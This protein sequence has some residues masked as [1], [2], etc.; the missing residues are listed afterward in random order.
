MID[1]DGTLRIWGTLLVL[2]LMFCVLS[3]GNIEWEINVFQIRQ[4]PKRELTSFQISEDHVRW[5]EFQP[6]GYS[7]SFSVPQGKTW[8][9]DNFR[10]AAHQP[11]SRRYRNTF[12]E[13]K[14]WPS[15]V[16]I[17][18]DRS[19]PRNFCFGNTLPEYQPRFILFQLFV[20][21]TSIPLVLYVVF[22]QIPG[23]AEWLSFVFPASQG[24]TRAFRFGRYKSSLCPELYCLV[25]KMMTAE[26][27][28]S[29]NDQEGLN[30]LVRLFV[31]QGSEENQLE[32]LRIM[33]MA[34]RSGKTFE[35]Y[36]TQ[37]RARVRRNRLA[38]DLAVDIL[39]M[40]AGADGAILHQ[41]HS[42][43]RFAAKTFGVSAA[44]LELK[45]E[46]QGFYE[47]P[48]GGTDTGRKGREEEP[49][50]SSNNQ[51][52]TDNRP[53]PADHLEWAYK[54]LGCPLD[55]GGDEIK[56]KY[57]EAVKKYHPDSLRQAKLSEDL[58]KRA[59]QN[60]LKVQEAYETLE[61]A[62]RLER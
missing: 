39:I 24:F 17:V 58:R 62:G 29:Q 48:G 43:L 11:S 30:D 35:Q 33:Q 61:R 4:D 10:I 1:N 7:K 19:N 34:R 50:N 44:E 40:A 13:P 37:F 49:K 36:A 3:V 8:F 52:R 12:R 42:L 56:K 25:M 27:G 23:I 53:P 45:L 16:E 21:V 26:G 38:M 32:I 14:G 57:R 54:R 2:L 9:C 31:S 59:H 41:Q 18:F 46:Q 5:F 6:K 20:W 28:L 55:A 47:G 60:F 22:T 51:W 15:A